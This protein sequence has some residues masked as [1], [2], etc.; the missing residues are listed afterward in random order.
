[1]MENVFQYAFKWTRPTTIPFPYIWHRFQAKSSTGKSINARIEDLTP[2]RHDEVWTF[3]VQ[4]Y[5]HDE[6]IAK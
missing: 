5:F 3:F 6:P 4:H 1:M 2:D